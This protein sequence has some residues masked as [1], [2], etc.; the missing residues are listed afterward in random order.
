M[1]V[2]PD[3]A[4]VKLVIGLALIWLLLL[5]GVIVSVSTKRF[6]GWDTYLLA[7][8]IIVGLAVAVAILIAA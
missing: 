2:L 3:E 5:T 1:V 8:L 4:S 7:A 6:T